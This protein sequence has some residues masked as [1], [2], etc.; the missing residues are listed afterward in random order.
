MLVLAVVD[1]SSHNKIVLDANDPDSNGGYVT[2][3]EAMLDE[4]MA[5]GVRFYPLHE[6]VKLNLQDDENVA[7]VLSLV[8]H[9]RDLMA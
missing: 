6:L 7:I 9:R 8:Q 4:A 2:F 3:V 5:L 1:D